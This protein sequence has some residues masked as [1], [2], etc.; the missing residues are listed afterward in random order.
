MKNKE[1]LIKIGD[2]IVI[3]ALL[4]L[5]VVIFISSLPAQGKETAEAVISID[6]EEY[7]RYPLSEDTQVTVEQNGHINVIEIKNGAVRVVSA[8]C[9]DNTCVH[10][11]F[12]SKG[13]EVIVCLPAKLTVTLEG[14]SEQLDSVVY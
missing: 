8:N 4:I 3:A 14:A 7:A 2:I 13:S 12:I 11:G 10:Q 6:G 5:S 1:K 9:P